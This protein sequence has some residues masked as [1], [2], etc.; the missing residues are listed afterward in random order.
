M[1]DSTSLLYDSFRWISGS[2]AAN[3]SSSLFKE[4]KATKADKT[5]K[6]GQLQLLILFNK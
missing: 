2:V 5:L 4:V 1:K 3:I 6:K